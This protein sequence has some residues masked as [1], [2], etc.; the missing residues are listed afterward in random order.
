[1]KRKPKITPRQLDLWTYEMG[2]IYN[3]LEGEIIKLIIERLNKGHDNIL[4]WQADRLSE[5]GLFNSDVAELVAETTGIAKDR[6]IEIFNDVG[7]GAIDS[8]DSSVTGQVM[9]VPTN[10][11]NVMRGYAEQAWRGIDNLVNESLISQTYGQS[12][13]Q[14]AY[15]QTLNETQAMFNTGMYTFEQSL[16]RAIREMAHQGI[17]STV[18][19]ASGQTWNIEGH[20]RNI[21][22]TNLKDT[23]TA[24]THSRMG[25][26]GIHT[27]SV[28][29]HAGSRDK[30]S[31]IQGNVV[32]LRPMH[33][34]PANSKYRSI[35][36]PYWEADY[37]APDGHHG[38]IYAM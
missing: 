12:S 28:S 14:Q 3:A 19:N 29:S 37:L 21:L 15:L 9:D 23:Y 4:S 38:E 30:C 6:M 27:V 7:H 8:I 31:K 36:D 26:Y 33:E 1:M 32:D 5:L 11:D 20:V 16:E 2:N 10:L 13:A 35:Y 34:I 22:K 18:S 17:S 25:D 24:V